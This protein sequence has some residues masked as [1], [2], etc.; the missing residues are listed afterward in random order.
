MGTKIWRIILF[1]IIIGVIVFIY[2]S[3]GYLKNLGNYSSFFPKFGTSTNAFSST[4][5]GFSP[6]VGTPPASAIPYT[7]PVYNPGQTYTQPPSAKQIP[8]GYTKDQIS[9]YYG[10]IGI[11]SV[12]GGY[13]GSSGQIVL[14]S[15]LNQNETV[16]VTGWQLRGNRGS[17]FIPQAV[18]VYQP[19]GFAPAGDIHLGPAQS[20]Y[21][22]SAQG[23]IN[24]RLNKCIGYL[25][26][27]LNTNPPLP[28][29]CP[30]IDP[31]Q[32]SS[33][34]GACQNYILSL[35]ACTVPTNNSMSIPQND[36]ACQQFLT[37]LNYSGCF[38]A[39]FGERDFLSSQ[40]WVWTGSSI[41]DPYH[42]NI[43]LLDRNNLLVAQYSY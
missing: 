2:N 18:E 14:Y 43:R 22:Y 37:T 31:A 10:E 9:P 25:Q 26:K 32:L 8:A 36:Y 12:Y 5:P 30:N 40:W 41:A 4:P 16:D 23:T 7:P 15:Y 11:G 34:T 19:S 35:P 21:L 6:P 33:F 20:L 3:I 38:N 42:D 24:L 17:G 29:S 1:V 27:N 39:H 28:Q 13:G